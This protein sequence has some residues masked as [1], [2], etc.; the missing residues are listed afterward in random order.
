M[1]GKHTIKKTV[2]IFSMSA[3]GVYVILY[4]ASQD[5]LSEL[6]VW[7][8]MHKEGEQ[9]LDDPWRPFG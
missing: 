4:R 7:A 9:S 5:R 3:R 2:P 1:Y 6:G 8:V